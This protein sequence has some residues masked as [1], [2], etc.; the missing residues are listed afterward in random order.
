M[1][2]NEGEK[3]AVQT[4]GPAAE[5]KGLSLINHLKFFVSDT[6]G[7]RSHDRVKREGDFIH[8]AAAYCYIFYIFVVKCVSITSF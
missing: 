2:N 8:R 6:T 1:A 5:R 3:A 7:A 4:G